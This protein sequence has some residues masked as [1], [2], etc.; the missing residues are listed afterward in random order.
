MY[1][2]YTDECDGVDSNENLKK[3]TEFQFI[4]EYKKIEMC[5]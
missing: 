4:C 3:T 1:M 2:Y 5:T